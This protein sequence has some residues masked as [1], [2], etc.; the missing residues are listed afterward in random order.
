MAKMGMIRNAGK[1]AG[2]K[3]SRAISLTVKDIPIGDICVKSNARTE[4][5]GI[6][7]LAASI[8][9]YGLLQPIT[10][11]AEGEWFTVKAGHRRYMACKLLYAKEPERFHS[12]RCIVSDAGNIAVIQLVENVQRVDLPQADLFNALSALRE[13][14]MTLKQIAEVMGKTEGYIKSLFVGVNE[15]NRDKD[16]QNLI[17]D[18][19]IT[20]RD[21][22][23]TKPVK[24]K[25]QRLEIL[26]ER[27]SRKINREQ[28]REKVS[29]LSTPKIQNEKPHVV[30][31]KEKDRKSHI[32]IK[33]FPGLNKIIIYQVKG[34]NV[35]QLKSLEDDLR[36]YFSTNK[37][38]R[39]VKTKPPKE[40]G[41]T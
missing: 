1:G 27:K 33:A 37:E 6:E 16:Y 17:G 26:K 4:Y 28:M 8:R 25:N 36:A 40:G 34:R 39:I 12:I 20:I 2:T 10:V 9:Q 21:I 23:E 15:I 35:K 19:G 18:A 31:N 5:T 7:E 32:V 13:Q 22:A 3:D 41:C 11:Y 38:Y 30:S 29:E 24:D 14:G